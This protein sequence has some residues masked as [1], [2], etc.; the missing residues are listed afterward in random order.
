MT[1]LLCF[2]AGRC[3]WTILG[4]SVTSYWDHS[5]LHLW[6]NHIWYICDYGMAQYVSGWVFF[7]FSF[8]LWVN[9]GFVTE[10]LIGR[11]VLSVWAKH[12]TVGGLWSPSWKLTGAHWGLRVSS[13]A[14]VTLALQCWCCCLWCGWRGG[15]R[16]ARPSSSSSTRRT[17]YATTSWNM[18]RRVVE[19]RTRYTNEHF[20]LLY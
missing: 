15:I 16:N 3:F 7:Q 13:S 10:P 14:C 8:L 18:M 4:P 12:E 11:C 6:Q 9:G 1:S 2:R 5:S 19:R 20:M 17:T